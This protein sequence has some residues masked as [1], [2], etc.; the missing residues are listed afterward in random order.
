MP[1]R[2]RIDAVEHVRQWT[3]SIPLHYEYT[4]GVAGERFL[5][6]LQKGKILAGY[7]SLCKVNSLP[8]RTYC[9]RCYGPIRR[10]VALVPLGTVAALTTAKSKPNSLATF[11]FVRFEDTTGGLMHRLI[12][13][14]E[15]GDRVRPRFKP[16]RERTGSILDI[17][18]FKRVR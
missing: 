2:E 4:S 9:V 1:I 12:G 17:V 11:I 6:G 10:K 13:A 18:G 7:C 3:D 8:L 15:P 14:A 5:R 16:K